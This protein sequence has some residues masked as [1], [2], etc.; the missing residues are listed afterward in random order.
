MLIHQQSQH[1]DERKGFVRCRALPRA[2]QAPTL[3]TL[4]PMRCKKTGFTSKSREEFAAHLASID[5]LGS[6]TEIY[7]GNG[8]PFDSVGALVLH[9]SIVHP[10]EQLVAHVRHIDLY[11]EKVERLNEEEGE[12][13][14]DDELTSSGEEGEDAKEVKEEENGL[15]G[16]DLFVCGLCPYRAD[17]GPALKRHWD[18]CERTI[19]K[20]SYP[21]RHCGKEFRSAA[22]LLEHLKSH[23]LRRFW[24]ALSN[25]RSAL[26]A[27]VKAHLRSEHRVTNVKVTVLNPGKPE[28]EQE[29]L[30][31][32]R[33]ALPRRG[34]KSQSLKSRDV[35]SPADLE[36]LP[37]SSMSR[38]I[39]RCSECDFTT[40]VRNNFV[41]HLRLHKK[42]GSKE[43]MRKEPP[44]VT[45]INAPSVLDLKS[46]NATKMT[47]LLDGED[48]RFISEADLA[49]MPTLVDENKR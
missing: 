15:S 41:K 49:F 43:E 23:G 5:P 36:A 31:A 48:E 16:S 27:D 12:E 47:N 34:A 7:S 39:L 28:A 10:D 2:T 22:S 6:H 18:R 26:L 37:H 42:G 30:V 1:L 40:R 3:A 32:P 19:E 45:P 21:C 38:S 4:P 17:D 11:E 35:Y 8:S 29:F 24:S 25:F 20:I 9:T 14:D 44:S 33:N 13:V 46:A